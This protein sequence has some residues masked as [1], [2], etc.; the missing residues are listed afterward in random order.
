[1]PIKYQ[2]LVIYNKLEIFSDTGIKDIKFMDQISVECLFMNGCINFSFRRAPTQLL[3]LTLNDCNISDL[4]GLQQFQQLKKLELIKNTQLQSV[5]KVYSL[6][7]LLSLTICNTKLTNLVGIESLSKLK[8]IDLRD[9]CIVSV[10]PLK[11]LQYIKQL[12]LDNNQILDMEHLTTMKNY[13]SDWIYYQN[14]IEDAVL[15]KYIIDTNQ[16]LSLQE[17]KTSFEAKKCRTAELIRDYPAA[18][19]AKMKAKYQNKVN[20]NAGNGC[21][22]YL[23][24]NSDQELHDLHFVS[25]LGVTHLNL[26]SCQNTHALRVPVNLRAFKHSKSALKTA[27][28]IERLVGLELLYLDNNLIVELNIRGL[29]KLKEFNV[30]NNKIR[31]LNGA[32]YLKENYETGE[33]KQPSQEEIDEARLW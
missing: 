23:Y 29:D 11:N 13:N 6:V 1:M 14:E 33:Q 18:Y 12:L 10:E 16:N 24:I 26:F 22:P 2:P 3:Y 4:Q 28:G 17:L 5:E 21:G 31:D 9:N 15:N 25:E 7:N 20:R 27:K 32:E 19:D 8:Y 30:G